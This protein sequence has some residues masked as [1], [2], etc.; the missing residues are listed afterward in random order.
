MHGAGSIGSSQAGP[1]HAGGVQVNNFRLAVFDVSEGFPSREACLD[2]PFRTAGA[3]SGRLGSVRVTLG[4]PPG[5]FRV[6]AFDTRGS[7]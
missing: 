6:D 3:R 7:L 1:G 4:G 2:S 5:I